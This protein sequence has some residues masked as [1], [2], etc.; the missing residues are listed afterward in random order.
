MTKLSLR[1]DPNVFEQASPEN[2]PKFAL[3]EHDSSY[4]D[5]ETFSSPCHVF[6]EFEPSQTFSAENDHLH[7]KN[8]G[9]QV[10][11]QF[12]EFAHEV[13]HLSKENVFHETT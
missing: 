2:K 12:Q 13:D 7:A 3:V 5:F 4:H 9:P 11:D 6:S 8:V 1:P 10:A